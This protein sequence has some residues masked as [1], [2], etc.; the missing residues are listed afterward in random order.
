LRLPR[1]GWQAVS[2]PA[3]EKG[4]RDDFEEK[5]SQE[6]RKRFAA[7][8]HR[9]LRNLQSAGLIA[10]RVTKS[11]A[12]AAEY[13]LTQLGTTLNCSTQGYVP[14]GKT[15]PQARERQRVP[16]GSRNS[17]K[18]KSLLWDVSSAPSDP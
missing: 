1:K 17:I 18:R 4:V 11:K 6:A 12:L 14:L 8:S 9:T 15:V 2:V 16:S 3:C 13:S 10:K 7:H 5:F